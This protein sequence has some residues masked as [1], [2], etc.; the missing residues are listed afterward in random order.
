VPDDSGRSGTGRMR[1]GEASNA[2]ALDGDAAADA[3]HAKISRD[4]AA[5]PAAR[6]AIKATV[7]LHRRG[8]AMTGRPG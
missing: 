6:V 2:G 1:R 7:A 3:F 4:N 5:P 8:R